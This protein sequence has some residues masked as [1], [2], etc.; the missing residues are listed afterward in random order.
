MANPDIIVIGA[1]HNGLVAATCLAKAGRKVLV[2]E[3]RETP[4]GQLAPLACGSDF[5]VDALHPG[6]A[7]RADI[8]RE[9]ELERHGLPAPE[10]GDPAAYVAALPDGGLLRLS[11]SATDTATLDSIRALSARDAAQWPEFVRF[12]DV[13]ARFL[14]EA[15]RTPMPR[16][17]N[18]EV[19]GQGRP[20]ASLAWKLRRLG[21]KD[22][23][24]FMRCITMTAQEFGE[25]W[26]ESEPLRAAIGALAIHGLTIGSMSA[27]AGYTLLH[28][29]LNRGGLGHRKVPGG[30]RR[31]AE[32]LTGALRSHGAE[33]R[34]SAPVAQILVDR[35]VVRGVRLASG[36]EIPAATVLSDA[37]PRRTLL[38]LVGAAELPPEFVWQTQSIKMR[39]S[40]AKVHVLTDG[41]H[42][43]PEGT[44]V[45]A[46]SVKYLE[47]AYDAAKYGELSQQPYLEVTT[48][49]DV[50][51]IHFQFAPY[52]LRQGDWHGLRDTLERIAIHTVTERFPGFKDRVRQVRSITPLDL[53]QE[54]S[55]T[56]G[57]L[58]HGQLI[59][60]Q[61]LFMR[62][63]PGWSDHRTPVDGLYLCGSG[64]HGGGGVSGV[65]G[66]NAARRVLQLLGRTSGGGAG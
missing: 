46:P 18:A 39:G 38:G 3:R 5:V 60:D 6:G 57:D 12:M 17:T 36:E 54:W 27:G 19:L 31:I 63:M 9:L 1:G 37:D 7:L 8:A 16:M 22:M 11:S 29:W 26:F 65:S 56:E 24:R 42:G 10:G 51:S 30:T 2:L 53:E 49:D 58:N 21:R 13:A 15:Q 47:R 62:P 59:L 52:G 43:I 20:L 40:V 64:V 4:G 14:D 23:F 50:V 66:C 35:Q 45:I 44:V 55:L 61:L 34:T 33:L 41:S 25:E 32:A 28:N 48:A